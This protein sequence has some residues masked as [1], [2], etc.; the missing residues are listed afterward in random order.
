MVIFSRVLCGCKIFLESNALVLDSY[1]MIR[2]LAQ[3]KTALPWSRRSLYVG[4]KALLS[5]LSQVYIRDPSIGAM[6][7]LYDK[8]PDCNL[9]YS[10]W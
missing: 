1:Y 3:P 5:I 7:I 10:P 4:K 9:L 2:V 6:G 8:Q